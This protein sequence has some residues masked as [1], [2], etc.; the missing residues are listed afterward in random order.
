MKFSKV[1]L[2]LLVLSSIFMIA[3]GGNKPAV[4]AGPQQAF[5]PAWWNSPDTADHFYAYGFA[6]RVTG[7]SAETAAI[8]NAQS[9]AASQIEAHVKTMTENFMS[10]AGSSSPEL[11]TLTERVTRSVA[12]AKFTG[13]RITQ[14]WVGEP[15]NGRVTAYVQYAVPVNQVN[16]EYVNNIK[17]EEAL[18]TRFR[19][20]QAFERM[21]AAVNQ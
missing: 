17:S 14:S 3:C 2:V 11:L 21:E 9:N 10:E 12:N 5:R 6:E 15:V 8:A 16:R 13:A 20:Q 1:I 18:Y 4:P 19:A 7:E